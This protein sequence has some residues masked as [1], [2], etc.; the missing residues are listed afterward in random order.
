MAILKWTMAKS[1]AHK[2]S[3]KLF[4]ITFR[5]KFPSDMR[6]T[7]RRNVA[8]NRIIFWYFHVFIFAMVLGISWKLVDSK[9]QFVVVVVGVVGVVAIIIVIVLIGKERERLYL[10]DNISHGTCISLCLVAVMQQIFLLYL[11]EYSWSSSF[12]LCSVF[13]YFF[14]FCCAQYLW[15]TFSLDSFLFLCALLL[16]SFRGI[17]KLDAQTNVTYFS[18]QFCFQLSAEYILSK[19]LNIYQSI[20][21]LGATSPLLL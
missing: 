15:E 16:R 12:P 6:R 17:D 19:T 8:E 9:V 13:F 1:K 11:T 20:F 4:I 21:F 14:F 7:R 10:L 2:P 5:W 3:S 18:K